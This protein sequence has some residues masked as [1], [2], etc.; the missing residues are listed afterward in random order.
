MNQDIKMELEKAF[1]KSKLIAFKLPEIEK[2]E[3]LLQRLLGQ[4]LKKQERI[5][6]LILRADRDLLATEEKVKGIRREGILEIKNFVKHVAEEAEN[7]EKKEN[8]EEL[9][10]LMREI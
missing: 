4:D 10:K 2:R 7:A 1:K 3:E 8:E 9:E 6:E 5:L